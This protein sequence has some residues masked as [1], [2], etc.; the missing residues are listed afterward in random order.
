MH[1]HIRSKEAN[2]ITWISVF[3]EIVLAIF[4]II[5]GILGRSSAILADAFHSISDL[6]S[7]L[8]VLISFR[9]AKKPIDDTHHYGHGKFETLSAIVISIMI[10]VAAGVIFWNGFHKINR[11][12][13][14]E[15]I[16][17]PGWIAII[18]A[19]LSILV[20]E[21]LY[22]MTLR[23]SAKINSQALKANAWHHR[24]DALSSIAAML[25]VMGAR[26]LDESWRILDP[27]AAILVGVFILKIAI[28]IVKEG[29]NE[30]LEASLDGELNSKIL[31]VTRSVPGANNPHNLKTRKIGNNIS[32]EMHIKVSPSLS[33]VEAHDIATNVEDVLRDEFGSE[34]FISV[35]MEPQ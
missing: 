27:I 11:A 14:G 19:L 21:L 17:R 32:I 13:Q 7:D 28:N 33:I 8:V 12:M 25:G 26:F 4:K 29:M 1:N 16:A 10:F 34:T 15:L 5:A 9:F 6:V 2:R 23:V 31:E 30:L 18:A 24:S 22:R 35:H 3:W 20:K